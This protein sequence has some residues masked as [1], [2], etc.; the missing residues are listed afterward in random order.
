V[1]VLTFTRPPTNAMDLVSISELADRLALLATMTDEVTVVMVT[2]GI[3]GYFIAHADLEDLA[4]LGRGDTVTGDP[5]G[6]RRALHALESM[7]QP[8]V[9]AIDGQAWGGG[10][11]TA[12]ACTMRVGSARAHLALPEVSIGVIPGGGGTQRLPRVIGPGK[13]AE[14]CLSGRV[15]EAEEAERIGLLNA[16]LP[17]DDF[18]QQALEWCTG[19]ARHPAAAVLAAK[20]ALTEGLALPLLEGLRLESRLFLGLNASDEARRRNEARREAAAEGPGR[21]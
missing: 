20:Q 15:V 9:A 12:L 1:A 13:A 4:R 5:R 2:G 10:C 16:V 17:A 8:T 11:E 21:T 6:W 18:R 14:L 19:I 3:D 7:P